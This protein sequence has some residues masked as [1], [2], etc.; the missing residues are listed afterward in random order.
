MKHTLLTG[1]GPFGSVLNNPSKRLADHFAAN[2]AGGHKL[3]VHVFPVSFTD[4]AEQ[5]ES[6]LGDPGEVPYDIVLMMGVNGGKSE[7][8]IERFGTNADELGSID[9][10][11]QAA[12]GGAIIPGMP[13]QLECTLPIERIAAALNETNI[14]AVI[15]N[16]AGG[17]LC[18]HLLFR[19]LSRLQS[20]P[21]VIAGFI[22]LPADQ[23]TFGPQSGLDKRSF[24]SFETHVRAIETILGELA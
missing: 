14:P 2:G 12:S 5:L 22:H 15:S 13:Q 7:W 18:N 10:R 20:A 3:T 16:S 24:P 19:T 21:S 8:R 17:Y 23:D 1:F 9:M 6:L 4:V 11:D